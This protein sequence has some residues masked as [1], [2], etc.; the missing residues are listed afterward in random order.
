MS[1]SRAAN[2]FFDEEVGFEDDDGTGFDGPNATR[3][4]AWQL[5][6]R[7]AL[8][9][10]PR[11]HGNCFN[12]WQF[13]KVDVFQRTNVCCTFFDRMMKFEW[14]TAKEFHN[15]D[16]MWNH[17]FMQYL[18]VN[19]GTPEG[20]P[21]CEFCQG[22][23]RD[24]LPIR[25]SRKK[26]ALDSQ[27]ML[28]DKFDEMPGFVYRGRISELGEQL[29]ALSV[30]LKRKK[31]E[32]WKPLKGSRAVYRRDIRI[33]GFQNLGRV[34]QL[35]C[36]HAGTAPFLAEA[37]ND[38]TI[39]DWQKNQLENVGELMAALGLEAVRVPVTE[40]S[41]LPLPDGQ[42]DGVWIDGQRWFA[43]A[44]R[45]ELL[46]EARRIL[47]PGGRLRVVL[48]YGPGAIAQRILESTDPVQVERLCTILDAS[49]TY[50]GP[51][52]FVTV[53][54]LMAAVKAAGFTL[55]KER[56]P[57]ERPIGRMLREMPALGRDLKAIASRFRTAA[58]LAEVRLNPSLLDGMEEFM[59][60][61][62]IAVDHGHKR[63]PRRER[64][65]KAPLPLVTTSPARKL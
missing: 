61:T 42:F 19:M 39:V 43:R 16:G 48:A 41:T 49:G 18:R 34:A 36:S 58:F 46:A 60:Y 62:A 22:R 1:V 14:P 2:D 12:P 27:R 5:D 10:N 64:T 37:A 57:Q 56:P 65:T 15:E 59:S 13:L 63:H 4:D 25:A 8:F 40:I 51:G 24:D 45:Q 21:Y 54:T 50:D 11:M 6:K 20:V 3:D 32:I 44:G 9:M 31:G 17:P 7:W 33:S 53:E 30:E 35:G 55:D 38:L 28:Q 47:K 26:A 29:D 52:S 23:Q